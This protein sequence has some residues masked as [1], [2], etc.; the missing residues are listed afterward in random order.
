MSVV[1][2]VPAGMTVAATPPAIWIGSVTTLRGTV[3]GSAARVW[4][5]PWATAIDPDVP[6]STVVVAKKTCT[7]VAAAPVG[8]A[9]DRVAR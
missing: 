1:T 3:A 6:V 5:R 9:G 7:R 2:T 4:R 8:A